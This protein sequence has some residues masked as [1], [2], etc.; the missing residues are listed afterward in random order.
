MNLCNENYFSKEAQME[1]CGYSQFKNFMQCPAR[2]LAIVK[3]EWKEEE[4]D[5][6]LVGSFVDAYYEGTLERF[7]NEHP[8]IF[9]KIGKLRA[10]FVQAEKIIERLNRDTLFSRYMGGEKQVILTGEIKG[11]PVKIKIDSYHRGKCIV[12][13][14][15]LKDMKPVI[16][17]STGEIEDFIHGWFY[18]FEAAFYQ[19]IEGHGLPFFLAVGTKEYGTDIELIKIPQTW[20]DAARERVERDIPLFA[21]M[22]RGEIEAERCGSCA[23]CRSTKKLTRVISADEL[24]NL[25]DK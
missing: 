12:D 6:L 9:T 24:F 3:G 23:Y 18:D 4:T 20:I 16:N 7:K 5:A 25:E 17:D 1:Y 15:I 11:V 10:P 19:T 14:K 13:L 8:Q 2:A 21:A 22:K